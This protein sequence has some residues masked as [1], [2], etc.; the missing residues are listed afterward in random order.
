MPAVLKKKVVKAAPAAPV[1]GF[2]AIM[3]AKVLAA[4]VKTVCLVTPRF[5]R[6]PI[7][8]HIR[9]AAR[10]G[11][12]K[13]TGSDLDMEIT[14]TI[15]AETP[16]LG[17]V[18]VEG[19]LLRNFVAKI[20]GTVLI[21]ATDQLH[22]R[23]SAGASAVVFPSLPEEDFPR[24][25][26]FKSTVNFEIGSSVLH[27]IIKKT[28]FCISE[29][30]T[31]YYLNGI[32]LHCDGKTLIAEATDGHRLAE[33]A[34]KIPLPAFDK[35]IVPH[36]AV[37]VVDK[38]TAKIGT[39]CVA[40]SESRIRFT[41]PDLD[42]TSKLIDGTF[43]ET[44]RVIPRQNPLIVTVD[45]DTLKAAIKVVAA[46]SRALVKVH[47]GLDISASEVK[48][49]YTNDEGISS[50]QVIDA[51]YS[52]DHPM[53][54]GF[55]ARYLHDIAA[56]VDGKTVEMRIRSPQEP[57]TVYDAKNPGLTYVLMPVRI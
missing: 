12:V 23:V 26:D 21:S 17:T 53:K 54:I 8:K 33:Y 42:I 18:L 2:E 24:I 7:L 4:A 40:I 10:S 16:V 22:A 1:T 9:I 3:L 51:T 52:G 45:R 48:L 36:G 57:M 28:Q 38:A 35:I 29:E 14:A 56:H 20:D 32:C 44:S 41:A 13:I 31:R 55:N 27:D 30:E 11:E 34:L 39:V 15:P 46:S 47:L 5:T 19:A 25:D 43:P 50:H 49:T 37:A 6:I